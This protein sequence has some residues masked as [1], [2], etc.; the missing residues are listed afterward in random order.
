MSSMKYIHD[1]KRGDIVHFR[2]ARF[3]IFEDAHESFGHAPQDPKTLY[4]TAIAKAT[5][6]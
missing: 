6:A 4:R 3:Q 1:F 2:G 5:G